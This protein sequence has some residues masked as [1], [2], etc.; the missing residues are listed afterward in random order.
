MRNLKI[1]VIC[2]V[3]VLSMCENDVDPYSEFREIDKDDFGH[4]LIDTL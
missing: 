4:T 2:T 3:M 1:I